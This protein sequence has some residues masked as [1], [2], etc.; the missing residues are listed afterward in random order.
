M[1]NS[2]CSTRKER[3][4]GFERHKDKWMMIVFV[5]YPFNMKY[6]P[7]D[8]TKMSFHWLLDCGVYIGQ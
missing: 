2:F 3:H 1:N 4:M 6:C 8:V 7:S 5:N